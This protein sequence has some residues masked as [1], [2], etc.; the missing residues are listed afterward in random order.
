MNRDILHLT[1]LKINVERKAI[2][3]DWFQLYG[4]MSRVQYSGLISTLTYYDVWMFS[5]R[6]SGDG[7]PG[8]KSFTTSVAVSKLSKLEGYVIKGLSSSQ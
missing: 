8:H 6:S 1:L 2:K 3:L 4:Y 5:E 7:Q